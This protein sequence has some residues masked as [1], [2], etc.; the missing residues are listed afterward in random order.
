M[1]GKREAKFSPVPKAVNVLIIVLAVALVFLFP[2]VKT[3][4]TSKNHD[5]SHGSSTKHEIHGSTHDPHQK[6]DATQEA[7]SS[8]HDTHGKDPQ[9]SHDSHDAHGGHGEINLGEAVLHHLT[10][11]KSIELPIPENT[12]HGWI[13]KAIPLDNLKFE[14]AG[15]DMSITKQV[16]YMW[17]CG[18][19]LLLVFGLS[20]RGGKL[21]RNKFAHILEVYIIFI[22]DE[23]VYPNVGEKEGRKLLP[24]LLTV[25][26]F[27]LACNLCGLVPFGHTATGN[28]NVTAGLALIAL[29]MIQVMG[30]VKNGFFGHFKAALL[31]SGLPL[32]LYVIMVPIEIIGIFAK[33]FALCVRLFANMV[34]GHAVILVLLMLIL[35]G[36]SFAL[37]PAPILG[38]LFISGLELFVAHLQAFIFT[39]LTTLFMSMTMHPEH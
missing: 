5:D 36:G 33:P 3:E 28:I 17:F 25:F 13:F 26:F 38:V 27:I 20:F 8:T 16:I 7:H 15:V 2:Y 35:K 29:F 11:M 1:K 14:V 18:L 10:D 39:I 23:V 9:G 21:L 4:A 12:A 22:R 37:A 24:F 32:P 34:A 30:V 31:P 19:I 6:H